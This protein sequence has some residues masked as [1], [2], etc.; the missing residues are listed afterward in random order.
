MSQPTNADRSVL[1]TGA[2]TGIGAAC[3][4]DL[5]KLGF[6][7]FAGVRKASDGE[8]LQA[9]SS[10]RLTPVMVD[11]ALAETIEQATA[12][13]E[14]MVGAAGLY[15]LVNN[16]GILI[17]GPLECVSVGDLRRQFDVNVLGV[18]AVTQAMLPLIRAA[19]GRIVNMGSLS[20]KAAPPYMGAYS[21]SKFALESITDVWRMELSRWN[22][23]VSIIEP[24]SVATPI[25]GKLL[26]TASQTARQLPAAVR[27]L[28]EQDLLSLSKASLRMSKTG[29]S[30]DHVV[31]AVRHALTA[32]RP[33]TRYPVGARTHLA[34]WAARHLPDRIRDGFMRRAMG[35]K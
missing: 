18:V 33:K 20:G 6:C 15:G 1:I 28:Y 23:D 2:S 5:D 4:L 13:I 24:D 19:Q 29:M 25:W 35:M 26:G 22:I 34:F 9:R 27:A 31:R 12:K 17:P 32:R 3:A 14:A 10:E 7:V 21:A 8:A 16:A 11:V 30:V